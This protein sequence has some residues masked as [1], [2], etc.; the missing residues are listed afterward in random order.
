MDSPWW[1]QFERDIQGAQ[2]VFFLGYNLND[3]AVAK[4]LTKDP[5]ISQK[6]RFILRD[7]VTELMRDRLEGYGSVDTFGVAGFSESCARAKGGNPISEFRELRAFRLIDPYQ[8]NKS[9][10]KPTPVEIENFLTRGVYNFQSLSSTYPKV[11]LALPRTSKMKEAS[12]KLLNSKTLL[13]HSRTAN[14]KS[15][16]A[17]MLSLKLSAEG[18]NCVRYTSH[19]DI[20]PSE[21][22]FLSQVQ[23]LFVF[24]R[25]YDDAVAVCEE[26]SELQTNATFI[27]E[28][29][30]GTDQVRR[31]E[32]HRYLPSPI[33]RLDLNSLEVQDRK[34]F[35]KLLSNAGIPP[36]GLDLESSGRTELRDH[37]VEL[38]N[39]QY[40]KERLRNV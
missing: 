23:D 12:D 34:D 25:T 1:D 15:V 36:G 35:G 4:Y 37:L 29:N 30:T 39:S 10:L 11:E 27:V 13:L 14:G 2:W 6:I 32:V 8:D 18:K 38:L 7:T 24:F 21:I 3:F 40:I 17:D 5:Q 22:E 19:S 16:F 26:T 9:I 33:G 20:P 31:S 28:I